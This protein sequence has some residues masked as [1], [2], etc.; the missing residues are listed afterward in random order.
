M[1]A[2]DKLVRPTLPVQLLWQN[3]PY[4]WT[5]DREVLASKFL[6]LMGNDPSQQWTLA[7]VMTAPND[8]SGQMDGE[9]L[10]KLVT[11]LSENNQKPILAFEPTQDKKYSH[12][13]PEDASEKEIFTA[14]VEYLKEVN[15]NLA[16]A[17]LQPFTRFSIEAGILQRGA[18]DFATYRSILNGE[19]LKNVELWDSGDWRQSP[20]KEFDPSK[21][22]GPIPSDEPLSGVWN[23]I[24]SFE[25]KNPLYNKATNPKEAK[26]LGTDMLE[27]ISD[28]MNPNLFQY[29]DRNVQV[30]NWSGE[31]TGDPPTTSN[32]PVFGGKGQYGPVKGS[33]WGLE[34]FNQVLAA[35]S[36]A[37]E[38]HSERKAPNLGI[39]GA[40][41]A[42]DHLTP[43]TTKDWLPSEAYVQPTDENGQKYLLSKYQYNLTLESSQ[44]EDINES[45][46]QN[47]QTIEVSIS[48]LPRSEDIAGIGFYKLLDHQGRVIDEN[49]NILDVKDP[50]YLE[51]AKFNAI[52]NSAWITD[53]GSG[54][55]FQLS[56]DANSRYAIII[57]DQGSRGASSSFIA[58][59]NEANND[60]Q[61]QILPDV[62]TT[63]D[64]T[65]YIGVETNP[66]DSSDFNDL[67]FGIK[68]ISDQA[69]DHELRLETDSIFKTSAI[70]GLG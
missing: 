10:V 61:I 38:D 40:E 35:Y 6:A 54:D 50:E 56:L 3:H 29:I 20:F 46:H 25:H 59:L 58:S 13:A 44:S 15:K 2:S 19:G 63:D 48:R 5:A 39:W 27:T 34:D 24:Y 62:L 45:S 26:D 17:R 11:A 36:T 57:E 16:N 22:P 33:G 66:A 4:S 52:S 68:N 70:G 64:S 60:N 42:L 32:Q 55:S 47:N 37:F 31:N 69:F 9:K 67:I 30:F 53:P 49:E 65:Q 8:L 7:V 21:D 12:W 51:S 43:S 28:Q 18:E 23:Q 41:N 14:M 1:A